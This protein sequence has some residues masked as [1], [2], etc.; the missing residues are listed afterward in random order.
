MSKEVETID[1]RFVVYDDGYVEVLA[2]QPA[3]IGDRVTLAMSN[4]LWLEFVV[5]LTKLGRLGKSD[6]LTNAI[7]HIKEEYDNSAAIEPDRMSN[8]GGAWHDGYL[9]GLKEA[10]ECLE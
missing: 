5:T 6:R 9:A 1:N 2:T 7:N 10:L 3:V 8:D 4:K